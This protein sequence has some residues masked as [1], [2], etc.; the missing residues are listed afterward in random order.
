M[1]RQ[2]AASVDQHLPPACQSSIPLGI[3]GSDDGVPNPVR[4]QSPGRKRG[5]RILGWRIECEDLRPRAAKFER[6]CSS[7]SVSGSVG[8]I[9]IPHFFT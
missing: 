2:L 5:D 9:I 8:A 1:P 3:E 4:D 7:C 6:V